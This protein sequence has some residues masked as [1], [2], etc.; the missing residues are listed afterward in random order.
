ARSGARRRG[1]R[2]ARRHAR[3]ARPPDRRD[4]ARGGGDRALLDLRRGHPGLRGEP[5]G[6]PAR[7]AARRR[8]GLR[9]GRQPRPRAPDRR[10]RDRRHHQPAPA[11]GEP[12]APAR[13]RRRRA[14]GRGAARGPHRGGRG[15]VQRG[16]A[17]RRPPA[18]RARSPAR[19]AGGRAAPRRAHPG[20]ARRRPH[21]ARR[22]RAADHDDRGGAARLRAGGW[23]RVN[24][25]ADLRILGV[26]V[27][28]LGAFQLLP[29]VAALVYREPAWPWLASGGAA[30]ALGL[31]AVLA[32]R[33]RHPRLRPRD[34]HLI[35]AAGWG[36]ASLAG[37]APFWLLGALGPVDALFESTSGITTTGATVM[38]GLD[39]APRA[40]L[41]WR[42]LS[43]WIGGMGIILF[44]VAVLP[45]LGIGG[46]Q[47]FRV[48]VP[49][50][51]KDKLRPRVIETARRLWAVYVGLTGAQ[52]LAL[53]VAGMG[54]FD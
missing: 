12:R 19:R 4:A 27:A 13:A 39:Q 29:L 26:L 49:G 20:A 30:A 36:L 46:M 2:G 1:R 6:G 18:R 14:L 7:A 11:R 48:E 52:W 28:A 15:G 43:Q 16:V 35:V 45:L 54:G 23:R 51:V 34:A 32:A 41:L 38:T 47:L 37:A 50:P 22:P 24:L 40:L 9:A 10:G 53:C 33:P 17:A 21:R 3:R 31:V 44:A 42:A 8:A 5:G 25:R